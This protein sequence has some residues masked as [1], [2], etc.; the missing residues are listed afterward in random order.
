MDLVSIVLGMVI[1][2]VIGW[3][4]KPIQ[5]GFQTFQKELNNSKPKPSKPTDDEDI[6]KMIQKQ[7]REVMDGIIK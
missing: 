5:K 7:N 1:G 3:F 4:W 6:D 2:F